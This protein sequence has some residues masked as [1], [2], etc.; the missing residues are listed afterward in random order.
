M[1]LQDLNREQIIQLKQNLYCERNENASY[2][3]LA[4]IDNLVSD[5]ELKEEYGDTYFVDEDFFQEVN[6][7][8]FKRFRSI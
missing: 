4:E 8:K 1:K 3:E 5:E 6:Y 2:G 7:G